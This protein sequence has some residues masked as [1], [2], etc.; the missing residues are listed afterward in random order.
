MHFITN[1]LRKV[2]GDKIP[3]W[4]EWMPKGG[5][6]PRLAT[7]K[8][9]GSSKIVYFPSCTTRMMGPAKGD[10]DKRHL[11][12]VMI[13]LLERAGFE[14]VMPKDLAKYCCG[15]P[16]ESMGLFKVA[17]KLCANL[18]KALLA[19]SN[20]GEYPILCDMSPCT[21]RMQHHMD[22]RLKIYDTVEFIHDF[23]LTGWIFIK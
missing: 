17:D 23:C 7:P 4:T 14:V 1:K 13:E 10:H 5:E 2:S 22:A 11:S 19:C 9:A 18:E 12:A 8:K 20:N 3:L 21:Y 6:L 16:F 15:M